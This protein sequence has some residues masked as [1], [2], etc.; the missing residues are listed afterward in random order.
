MLSLCRNIT[1]KI[2]KKIRDVSL[3]EASKTIQIGA[4][5]EP[6]KKLDKIAED[7]ALRNLRNCDEEFSVISEEVGKTKIGEN[8]DKTI[9]VDPIDG[10][11]NALKNIPFYSTS[12]AILN[13]KDEIVFS[14][15]KD[16]E[17]NEEYY[18]K[19]DRSYK[20]NTKLSTSNVRELLNSSVSF[21]YDTSAQL[22]KFSNKFKHLR[23]LGCISL[24]LCYVASGKFDAFIDLR[25]A[26]IIDIAAGIKL[27][28]NAGGRY[29]TLNTE[30]PNEEIKKDI[31]TI[32]SNRFLNRALLEV[33]SYE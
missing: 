22:K 33:L 18:T 26:G 17:K 7:V 14:F 19:N 30:F 29:K 5:G 28:E 11:H 2:S 1:D 20:D 24:E 16:Y 3:E 21:Y 32:A 23:R 27:I 13:K 6:T 12:I 10:T 31:K 4:D 8:P 9:I 25:G 15:V